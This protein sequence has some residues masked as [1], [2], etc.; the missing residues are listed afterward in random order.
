MDKKNKRI[1]L[2]IVIACGAILLGKYTYSYRNDGKNHPEQ[3][4]EQTLPVK[5]QQKKAIAPRPSIGNPAPYG[6]EIGNTTEE[7]VRNKFEVIAEDG[8][9]INKKYKILFLNTK[10]FSSQKLPVSEVELALDQNGLV[11]RFLIRYDGKRF[12]QLHPNLSK[13]YKVTDLNA[14]VVGD[15]IAEYMSKNIVIA[16]IEPHMGGF[17]TKLQNNYND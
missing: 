4:Q 9:I 13:K 2:I 1:Y 3:Q 17:V 11:I 12:S 8:C 10:D 5:L 7:E 15:K 16:L 6:I 14:P